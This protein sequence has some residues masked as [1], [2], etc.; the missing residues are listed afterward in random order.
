MSKRKDLEQK[1][2]VLGEM[3]T[4]VLAM[5]SLALMESKKLLQ[6]L[7]GQGSS[8][9]MIRTVAAD[10]LMFHRLLREPAPD[11]ETILIAVGADRG[12]CGDFNRQIAQVAGVE[13]NKAKRSKITTIAVGER[14]HAK[15]R[16]Q[17]IDCKLI[18][19]ATCME[20]IPGVLAS[21]A[22]SLT[23]HAASQTTDLSAIKIVAHQYNKAGVMVIEPC[24][25]LVQVS[26]NYASAPQL[27][28]APVVFFRGLM[29][30]YLEA[31]LYEIFYGSL[32]A[33]NS[34]RVMHLESAGQRLESK[35]WDL[36]REYNKLRQEE[37]TEEIEIIML[38]VKQQAV[39]GIS[40]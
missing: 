40:R 26:S 36:K 13:S 37:I 5:K 22:R 31:V 17:G 14:L 27:T 8:L 16:A 4:I 30:H 1:L 19:G 32:L 25:A 35:C 10:F 9:S 34:R 18:A 33:E 23:E 6:R 12:F 38:S 7:A 39:P 29:Q 3:G 20:D 2:D 24:E 21:L 28:L 11:K 15:M